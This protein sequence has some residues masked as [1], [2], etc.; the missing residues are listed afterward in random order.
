LRPRTLDHELLP[1]CNARLSAPC[2]QTH[3]RRRRRVLSLD[4]WSVQSVSLSMVLGTPITA[5]IMHRAG[6]VDSPTPFHAPVSP[7]MKTK[8]HVNAAN[9]CR[10][11]R[12]SCGDTLRAT[13]PAPIRAQGLLAPRIGILRED[14]PA[15]AAPMIPSLAHSGRRRDAD[16]RVRIPHDP[17]AR[18]ALSTAAV[19]ALRRALPRHFQQFQSSI[20][21]GAPPV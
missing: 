20:G 8:L 10:S 4:W 6:R 19:S 1:A 2:A 13:C 15:K 16:P 21:A 18:L 11:L 5:T 9:K 3:R 17:P 12:R 14:G 7:V